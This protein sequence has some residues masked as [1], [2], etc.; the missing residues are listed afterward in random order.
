MVIM[1]KVLF[2]IFLA[3]SSLFIYEEVMIP[4]LVSIYVLFSM[5]Y[6]LSHRSQFTGIFDWEEGEEGLKQES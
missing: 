3:I 1:K 2:L 4:V 6:V 5:F